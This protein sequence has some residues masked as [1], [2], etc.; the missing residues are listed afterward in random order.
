MAQ[1]RQLEQGR[2]RQLQLSWES[3]KVG[4]GWV[5]DYEYGCERFQSVN[6]SLSQVTAHTHAHTHAQNTTT[7]YNKERSGYVYA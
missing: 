5:Y 1:I 7:M 6:Q 2:R 4:G 3:Q